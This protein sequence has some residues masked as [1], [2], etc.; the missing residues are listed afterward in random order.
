MLDAD[1][2]DCGSY[3]MSTSPQGSEKWKNLRDIN[4]FF[5]D[6]VIVTGSQFNEACDIPPFG[7][8]DKLAYAKIT[9]K[10]KFFAPDALE[11]MRQGS[12]HE[13]VIRQL[14]EREFNVEVKEVGLAIPKWYPY[15]GSSLDG[16]VGDDGC[17]EIK[18]VREIKL[19]MRAVASKCKRLPDWRPNNAT[20]LPQ[21]Y[22]A[23]MQGGM[24]ITGRKWCDF[25]V[26]CHT[27]NELYT[28]KIYFDPK[29][30]NEFLFPKLRHFRE[31][32]V[33]YIREN[34]EIYHE[35]FRYHFC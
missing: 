1:W 29:Y 10:K 32:V 22:Y 23:Q 33:P 26:Y 18:Y 27:T 9:R 12:V 20:H 2:V 14:Y 15:I 8:S 5:P 21:N 34:L 31:V 24:A 30:W 6:D 19:P 13:D 17:I 7:F 11:R 16:M 35:I 28:E 25:V 3:V 4:I